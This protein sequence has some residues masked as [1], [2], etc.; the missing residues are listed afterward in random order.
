MITY[1]LSGINSTP[2]PELL[3]VV[4]FAHFSFVL[5][6]DIRFLTILSVTVTS[7]LPGGPGG[8]DKKSFDMYGENFRQVNILLLLRQARMNLSS[9]EIFGRITG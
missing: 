6:Y 8:N 5:L 9:Y 4:L 1:Q 2:G 3:H 7:I